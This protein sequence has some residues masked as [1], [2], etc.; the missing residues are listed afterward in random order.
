MDEQILNDQQVENNPEEET[1]EQAEEILSEEQLEIAREIE[2]YQTKIAEL[3]VKIAEFET[4]KVDDKKRALM[5]KWNY[6]DE[7]I[8]RY[9]SHIE[10]E[11]S[12]DIQHSIIELTSHIPPR[13]DN[14]A[15][16]SPLNGAKYKPAPAD[17][18][19]VGKTLFE[20]IKHRIWGGGATL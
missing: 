3:D 17:P 14:Y 20:R 18:G 16:P 5:R 9:I 13:A 7:Q 11:T 6:T 4:K 15:D 2:A 19:E 1:S 10:G 8:E 12:E